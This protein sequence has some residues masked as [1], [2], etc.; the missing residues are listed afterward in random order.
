MNIEIVDII[1]TLFKIIVSVVVP[2]VAGVMSVNVESWLPSPTYHLWR[3]TRRSET[4]TAE[5]ES[6]KN[7]LNRFSFGLVENM[8]NRKIAH[9]CFRRLLRANDGNRLFY[10]W[11]QATPGCLFASMFLAGPSAYAV[12]RYIFVTFPLMNPKPRLSDTE[13][14]FYFLGVAGVCVSIAAPILLSRYFI[15][16]LGIREFVDPYLNR[17]YAVKGIK[18][19]LFLCKGLLER[20]YTTK[21]ARRCKTVGIVYSVSAFFIPILLLIRQLWGQE[22]YWAVVAEHLFTALLT[23]IVVTMV[24][25]EIRFSVVLGREVKKARR[26]CSWIKA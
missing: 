20:I 22:C 23:L 10:G 5:M 9:K 17:T 12:W 14:L 21:T 7:D 13:F 4:V 15:G 19:T 25:V 18:R 8:I 6:S 2:V 1:K 11:D 16:N 3:L 24:G 26:E